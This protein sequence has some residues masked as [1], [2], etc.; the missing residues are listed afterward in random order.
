MKRQSIV[1]TLMLSLIVS[2]NC[3]CASKTVAIGIVGEAGLGDPYFPTLGNGGYD[4]LHYSL[5]LDVDMENRQ[6]SAIVTMQAIARDSLV[7]FNLDFLGF[8]INHIHV[9]NSEA[10]FERDLRELIISPA[11]QINQ[12]DEFTVTVAY[13]GSP[14]ENLNPDAYTFSQGW[15]WIDS[16]SFVASEPDGASLWYPVNDHPSDKATYTIEVTVPQPYSVVANGILQDTINESDGRQTFIWHSNDLMASYLVTVNIGDFVREDAG[17]VNGVHL[18]NY[19]PPQYLSDGL[20]T[21]SIHEDIMMLFN[22]TFGKYPFEAYGGIIIDA[23]LP[24]ALETQSISLF[25]TNI[26]EDNNRNPVTVAHEMAHSWFGNH[27]S[28]AT[29]RDIWLNESFATYASMLWLED[30]TSSAVFNNVMS[31]QYQTVADSGIRIADPDVENLFAQTVYW[32]GAWM[33]KQLHE[34]LGDEMFFEIIQAYQERFANST[35]STEDFIAVA[36]EISGEDLSEFFDS[37]LYQAV[38]P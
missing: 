34:D 35:A 23:P 13:S 22:D 28:P 33:L 19:Y 36:E 2:L 14:R 12:G 26:L 3:A 27:V 25:G 10:S 31:E 32:G 17:D 8:K 21:F 20:R 11:E 4:A 24:F 5:D 1:I 16:G 37:W 29:W 15:V 18:R 9:N 6:F 7:R 38:R 30:V